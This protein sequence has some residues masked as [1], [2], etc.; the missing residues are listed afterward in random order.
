MR[1]AGNNQNAH[2]GEFRK[3]CTEGKV[4]PASKGISHHEVK[5]YA[6]NLQ[7]LTVGAAGDETWIGYDDSSESMRGAS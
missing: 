2:R 4:S 7:V 1:E 3:F 6:N 5:S